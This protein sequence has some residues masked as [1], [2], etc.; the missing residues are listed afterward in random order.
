MSHALVFAAFI[1]FD[2]VMH[3]PDGSIFSTPFYLFLVLALR[4]SA[5][6]S[7]LPISVIGVTLN[8]RELNMPRLLQSGGGGDEKD[9]VEKKNGAFFC[10]FSLS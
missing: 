9:P 2:S 5:S 7:P 4:F 3:S 1:L 6:L 8:H 10:V